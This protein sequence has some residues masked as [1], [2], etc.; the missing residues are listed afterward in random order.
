MFVEY[1]SINFNHSGS[2]LG[3]MPASLIINITIILATYYVWIK[4]LIP[5]TDEIRKSMEGKEELE[6]EAQLESDLA[7]F[8]ILYSDYKIRKKK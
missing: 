6:G 3:I 7:K 8:K 2:K 4:I 5:K 1:Q